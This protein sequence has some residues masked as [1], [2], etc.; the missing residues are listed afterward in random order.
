MTIAEECFIRTHNPCRVIR[1][2][3]KVFPDLL[4]RIFRAAIGWLSVGLEPQL[5]TLFITIEQSLSHFRAA[6]Y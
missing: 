4:I 6:L 2:R 3:S 1:F 5:K